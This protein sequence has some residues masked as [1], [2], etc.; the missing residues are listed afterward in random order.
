MRRHS[1]AALCLLLAVG[2]LSPTLLDSA[3]GATHAGNGADHAE[4]CRAHLRSLAAGLRAYLIHHNAQLPKSL[5]VLY[6]EGYV[7]DLSL[8]AC[9]ASGVHIET[10]GEIDAKTTYVLAKTLEGPRPVV[11]IR[12]KAGY[13]GTKALGFCSDFQIREVAAPPAPRVVP[14]PEPPPP[15]GPEPPTPEPPGPTPPVV[16]PA[17]SAPELHKQGVALASQG[18]GA[19]AERL[20]AEALR[21]DGRNPAY[22]NDLGNV[23]FQQKKFA[24]A[25]AS[26][27]LA[28]RLAPKQA[29]YHRNQA[30]ALVQLG[31]WKEAV[32]PCAEAVRLEPKNAAL[33]NDLGNIYYHQRRWAEASV[34]YYHAVQVAPRNGLYHANYAGTLLL[35]GRRA[36]A[37]QVARGALALGHRNHWVYKQLGLT[38]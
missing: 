2:A 31:K 8:L 15:P 33:H 6:A 5:G 28:A 24:E 22:A 11:L 9:P 34:A 18:R 10:E 1:T 17:R 23:Q 14:Q 7:M 16:A 26:F 19:E 27:A 20:L 35:L 4:A 21:L 29:A 12:G 13:H 36:D 32:A 3:H 25:A 37:L 30:G 38:P